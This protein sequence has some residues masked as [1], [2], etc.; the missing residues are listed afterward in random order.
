[1]DFHTFKVC[2][3]FSSLECD[4]P[5]IK[6]DLTFPILRVVWTE[7][8]WAMLTYADRPKHPLQNCRKLMFSLRFCQYL[9]LQLNLPHALV[10]NHVSWRTALICTSKKSITWD[11]HVLYLKFRYSLKQ[12]VSPLV[13]QKSLCVPDT[14]VYVDN[15]YINTTLHS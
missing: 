15:A 7:Q 4:M 2:T 12:K 1:M 8:S 3:A 5:D 9:I 14:T 13:R 11:T 6:M 10:K